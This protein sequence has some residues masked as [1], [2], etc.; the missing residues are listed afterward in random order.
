MTK[1]VEIHIVLCN[2][3]EYIIAYIPVFQKK[4]C[5]TVKDEDEVKDEVAEPRVAPTIS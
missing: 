2:F 3:H 5:R 1:V 4:I